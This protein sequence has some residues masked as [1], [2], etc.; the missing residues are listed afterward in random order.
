LYRR[1]NTHQQHEHNDYC[2]R[3]KKIRRKV[4]RKCHFEFPRPVIKTLNMKNVTNSIAG[5][6]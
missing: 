5:K 3:S 2:L 4:I 1:V 6:K